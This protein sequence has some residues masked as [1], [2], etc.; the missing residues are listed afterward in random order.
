[1]NTLKSIL[2]ATTVEAITCKATSLAATSFWAG[3]PIPN[4]G[5][6]VNLIF[7]RRLSSTE[8]QPH[9]AAVASD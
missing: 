5:G 4:V 1:M 9:A 6:S 7:P 2:S 8:A 3:A